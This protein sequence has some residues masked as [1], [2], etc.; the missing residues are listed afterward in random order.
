MQDLL[1][2]LLPSS[3]SSPRILVA[4]SFL[5]T[6]DVGLAKAP[7]VATMKMK[8]LLVISMGSGAWRGLQIPLKCDLYDRLASQV[9]S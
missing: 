6:T 7:A 9:G 3:D 8:S 4:N 1:K 5:V 2:V